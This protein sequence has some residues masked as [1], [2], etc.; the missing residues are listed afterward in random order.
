MWLPSYHLLI[1]T[2]IDFEQVNVIVKRIF[3]MIE[4]KKTNSNYV[5]DLQRSFMGKNMRLNFAFTATEQNGSK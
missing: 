5:K 3:N 4:K 2:Q 1:Q